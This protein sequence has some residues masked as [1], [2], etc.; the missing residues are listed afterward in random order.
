MKRGL[1][2]DGGQVLE[3]YCLD[4]GTL[5]EFYCFAGS[6][7]KEDVKCENGCTQG[8]CNEKPAPKDPLNF[9]L[10]ASPSDAFINSCTSPNVVLNVVNAPA[11]A[12][13]RFF[14]NWNSTILTGSFNPT[15]SEANREGFAETRVATSAGCANHG[16][17]IA[18]FTAQVCD[19]ASG[20]CANKSFLMPFT[21]GDCYQNQCGRNASIAD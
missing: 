17:T 4:E 1:V 5:V 2:T 3:D 11:R 12:Q 14:V 9:T 19:A 10:L 6:S 16:T 8:A 21:A 13:V 18:T 20:R 7:A 15:Q